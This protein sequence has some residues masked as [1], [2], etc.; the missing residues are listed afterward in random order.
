[1]SSLTYL[2]EPIVTWLILCNTGK[3][4]QLA[5]ATEAESMSTEHHRTTR[6]SGLV[7]AFFLFVLSNPHVL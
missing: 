5:G 4:I 1:M 2:P 3:S 7:Y 6:M